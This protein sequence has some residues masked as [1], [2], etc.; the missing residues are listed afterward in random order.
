M[1]RPSSLAGS[2]GFTLV[3]LVISGALMSLILASAYLCLQAS[4][5]TQRLLEPRLE[6]AQSGR[7]ALALMAADLRC[8]CPL[9]EDSDFIGMDR[10]LGEVE[11]DN[12]DFA[13]HHFTPRRPG[14]GDY[15]QVSYFLDR[16]RDSG[17]LSLWRRRNPVLALD[18]LSGGRRE[19]L[20]RRVRA[21]RFEYYDGLDWYDRW[22]DPEGKSRDQNS[23]RLQPNLTGMPEAV[24]ITLELDA[25]PI[26]GRAAL[27]EPGPRSSLIFQTVARLNLSTR[28]VSG[29]SGSSSPPASSANPGGPPTPGDAG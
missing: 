27:T 14:E 17:E 20:A 24:R 9:S 8:A 2:A 7:V 18:P 4:F 6:A 26:Q 3:E 25:D 28:P 15:C 21:L 16:N 10:S 22:G 11:A 5:S 13:T 23:Y 29:S 1:N 19:E 12:L